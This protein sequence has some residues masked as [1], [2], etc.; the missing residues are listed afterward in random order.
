MCF[1]RTMKKKVSFKDQ[2]SK[3][4]VSLNQW[5]SMGGQFCPSGH[6]WQ[7]PNTFLIITNGGRCTWQPVRAYGVQDRSPNKESPPQKVNSPMLR[8]LGVNAYEKGVI[9]T[10]SVKACT[11]C[12][13]L[14][15]KPD[16]KAEIP[17]GQIPR[18]NRSSWYHEGP[19]FVIP[20]L[21]LSHL[22]RQTINH[23]CMW[24]VHDTAI[25]CHLYP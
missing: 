12:A 21:G 17:W 10:H 19:S 3:L 23:H 8:N 16:K 6:T 4:G 18:W 1:F 7:C 13:I 11:K 5:S 2:M 20:Y 15:V 25:L 22:R 14:K 9:S 24:W